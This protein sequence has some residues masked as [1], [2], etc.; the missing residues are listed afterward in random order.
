VP[1]DDALARYRAKRDLGRS[2]EPPGRVRR[3]KAKAR[4]FVVQKHA[5]TRLHWDL[6]LE[7][8]GVLKSWAVAR[9]PSLDPAE[10]RLA[11][12]VEDHPVDYAS[13]EGVIPDGYGK[14]A[15]IVWDRGTWKPVGDDPAADL[16]AGHLK[17]DVAAERMT[18]RWALVRV[19]PKPKERAT[20]W[21]LIKDRDGHARPGS[22]DALVCDHAASVASDGRSKTWAGRAPRPPPRPLRWRRRSG[23]AGASGARTAPL[24]GRRHRRTRSSSRRSFAKPR[25]VRRPAP[26]GSTRPS[27]TATASRRACAAARRGC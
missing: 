1:S 14:G 5:A 8:G 3:G 22:G 27:S 26:G 15:V 18:G 2:P 21:L 16:A 13:F 11:V 25:T 7:L 4:V 19:K 6:R 12:E 9:G 20:N 23:R 24:R 10:R 17:F